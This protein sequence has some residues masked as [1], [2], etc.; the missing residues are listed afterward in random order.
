MP[1]K[2]AGLSGGSAVEVTLADGLPFGRYSYISDSVAAVYTDLLT[3]VA[4]DSAAAKDLLA[5]LERMTPELRAT[6]FRDS[7][8]RRT[9]EDGVCRILKGVDTIEP[10]ALEELLGVTSFAAGRRSRTLLNEDERGVCLGSTPD[11]GYVWIGEQTG[12]LPGQQ[13]VDAILKR[14]PG[15]RI[16]SA[17]QNQIDTLGRG[18]RLASRAAPTLTDSALSHNFMVVLGDFED[19]EQKFKS[20]TLPGLPGVLIISPHVLSSDT[21]TAEAL[22]HEAFH[23]KFLD[24]DY[25]HPLFTAEFRQETSPRITPVWHEGDPRLGHW[26]VDRVLT[27]MHVYLTLAVFLE[28]AA[29]VE[30]IPGW[31]DGAA[32]SI[33]CRDKATWLSVAA[34]DHLNCLTDSGRQF[35]ASIRAMLAELNAPGG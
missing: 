32:R 13:F 16:H 25:I 17:T 2:S 26:P 22:L 30:D 35:V 34:Q 10:A 24:I 14:L 19:E 12:T 33:E 7:L 6:V 23:L 1:L 31:E 28:K 29:M 18:A 4:R 11:F 9:I 15:F 5:Q 3:I 8:V 27:S 21:A 20:L